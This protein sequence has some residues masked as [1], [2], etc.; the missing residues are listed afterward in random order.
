M[1]ARREK[2]ITLIYFV[3]YTVS[4][5]ALM[6]SQ[7]LYD[8]L[9][10]SSPPDEV[11]RYRVP[12]Y[13]C[14]HGRLP[15]GFEEELVVE[16]VK[17]TYGFYTLLPYIVQG[18][19]MRIVSV[20]TDSDLALLY[21]ARAVNLCLG[22]LMAHVVRLIGRAVFED[23]RVRWIFCFLVMFM[24]QSLFVHTYV[25]PDSMCM[26]STALMSYGAIS[27]Y[28]SGF[29]VKSCLVMASG[30]VLCT[31]SYYN[32]YGFILGS[33]L[34][35]AS[36][37]V[38]TED[39]KH[40]FAWRAFLRR[41]LFI[42]AIVVM[43]TAWHFVRNYCLYDGDFIG[44]D[45]KEEFIAAGGIIR[46]THRSRGEPLSAMLFGTT[47]IPKLVVSFISNY[48]AVAIYAWFPVYVF[49]LA[50][51][52]VGIFG[53]VF[54]KNGNKRLRVTGA[55]AIII[56][57]GM[58]LCIVI[59]LILVVK[60][61][62]T[63]DYQAQGR[64]IMPGLI[65]LM[66]YVCHGLEKLPVWDNAAEKCRDATAAALAAAVVAALAVSIGGAMPYYLKTGVL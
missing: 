60:Y 4:A 40:K 46:D 3:V 43:C 34:W 11:C 63:I 27:G 65:P 22:L 64:Y 25:N 23:A 50:L 14:S 42:V 20:F 48:G 30:V 24:P 57:F 6:L 51:F 37:F 21:A 9:T 19:A 7:P 35:F 54:V 59:P 55:R 18:Y 66:Y 62:Y 53:M 16:G 45:T 12:V 1:F 33:A 41:G 13:I 47:F 8:P 61:A 36:Y 32:A 31:L 44:I 17:W 29:N 2:E 28:R 15:T 58:L 52:A 5:L 10:F 49:Y 38:H 26:L 39:E 56:H